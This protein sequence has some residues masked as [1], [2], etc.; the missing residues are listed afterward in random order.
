MG[1][2]VQ[3][4]G[5]QHNVIITNRSKYFEILA[6]F[7][8]AVF[9]PLFTVS[10]FN[11]DWLH[12]LSAQKPMLGMCFNLDYIAYI[13]VINV[14]HKINQPSYLRFIIYLVKS[15]SSVYRVSF[16][17]YVIYIYNINELYVYS[18]LYTCYE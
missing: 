15:L 5:S 8:L 17:Y 11:S 16:A 2:Q 9:K 12:T 6:T 18:S 10:H 4:L 13:A 1:S 7:N 3:Y 14:V